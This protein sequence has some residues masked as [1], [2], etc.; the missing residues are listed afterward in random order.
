MVLNSVLT[1]DDWT[2]NCWSSGAERMGVMAGLDNP[3]GSPFMVG[4]QQRQWLKE[5]LDKVGKDMPV[6]VLSHSPLQK[7]YNGWNF[8]T[9]DAEETQALLKPFDKVTVLYGHVHQI[10]YNQIGNISFNSAMATAWPWPYPSTYRQ[11]ASHVP[12]LTVKMNRA[13]PFFERDATADIQDWEAAFDSVVK[14][15]RQAFTDPGLGSNGVV[16]AQCH[17]NAANTHPETYPKFQMQLGRV[18]PCGRWSTGVSAI[19]LRERIWRQTIRGCL[20]LRS[21]LDHPRPG[22]DFSVYRFIP[23]LLQVGPDTGPLHYKPPVGPASYGRFRFGAHSRQHR[24][25]KFPAT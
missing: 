22:G 19:P 20:L 13:D 11:A 9:E 8:W 21:V 16:C 18:V 17:P 1:C 2:Y 10:R 6:V 24:A 4:E 25:N 23:A 7:I 15:G 12:K 3:N 5:D 14:E